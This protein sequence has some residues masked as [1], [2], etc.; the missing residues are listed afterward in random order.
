[1]N[2]P[3]LANSLLV[4]GLTTLLASVLG[5]AVALAALGLPPRGRQLVLAGAVCTLVLPPFLVTGCW[6]DL[7]GQSANWDA[8]L[9]FSLFSRGGAVWLLTLLSWP[10]T[11]FLALGAW[12][13]L[14]AGQLEI[15]P[16][17]RG[18]TLLR[19]VLLPM[20]APALGQSVALTF[21][22]ALNNFAIPVILQVK[23]YPE[24]LWLAFTTRLD[25]AGAW[26]A[27]LPAVVAP[28]VLL[29][30]W[31][32]RGCP[33]RPKECPRSRPRSAV[34]WA[35]LWSGGPASAP[36]GSSRCPW[37]CPRSESFAR[38]ARGRSCRTFFGRRRTPS[39]TRL[40]MRPRPPPRA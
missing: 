21:V 33:G 11:T 37:P 24:E 23:V 8:S 9:P 22:L 20:A 38:P 6:L 4:S 19:R 15:E 12:S 35:R 32:G 26:A 2:W 40:P 28:L 3:L 17:L 10:V 31:R 29:L 18:W 14:E 1:M 13:R 16:R 30:L 36:W 27:C 7:L 5:A 39:G 25:E 34:S